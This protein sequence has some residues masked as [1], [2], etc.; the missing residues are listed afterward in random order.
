MREG[1][2]QRLLVLASALNHSPTVLL[3]LLTKLAS[4]PLPDT[5]KTML[6]PLRVKH[7]GAEVKASAKEKEERDAAEAAAKLG[8]A[9]GSKER[10]GVGYLEVRG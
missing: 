6:S 3:L 7:A 4:Q 2:S 9:S 10:R 1:R 8:G 5:S